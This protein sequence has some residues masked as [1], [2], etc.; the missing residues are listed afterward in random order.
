MKTIGKILALLLC[1][2]IAA[3]HLCPMIA[4]TPP[5]K[6]IIRF[7]LSSSVIEGD[8]NPDDAMAATKTWVST[9]GKGTGL[10]NN[11]DGRVYKDA[12]S[13]VAAISRGEA[14]IAAMGTQEYLEVEASL[15]VVPTLTYIQGGRVETEYLLLVRNDSGIK[16]VADLRGKRV[17]VPKSGRNSLAPLWLDVLLYENKLG[18][19][20]SFFKEVKQVQKPSQAIL[21]VFFNQIDAGIVIRSAFQTAAEL[22]PQ[23]GRQIRTL[24]TSPQLVMA[25][26]CL[27]SDLS[28]GQ[29]ERFIRE[30]LKLHE[31]TAGLQTFNIYKLDRLVVWDSSYFNNVRDFMRKYNLARTVTQAPVAHVAETGR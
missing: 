1:C 18:R 17:A 26:V 22:N 11:A 10:W 4:Q 28:V 7:A 2:V 12:A 14:D 15:Q 23:I 31:K 13:I 20:E 3:S 19:K 9:I 29:R 5:V 6:S 30:A 25:V 24:S 16:T 21:P 27:R 8:V